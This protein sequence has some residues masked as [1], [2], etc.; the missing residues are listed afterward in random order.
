MQRIEQVPR[1]NQQSPDSPAERQRER[2]KHIR[3][4][5]ERSEAG[6]PITA[7][8]VLPILDYVDSS[9]SRGALWGSA[10]CGTRPEVPMP[11]VTQ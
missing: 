6:L 9:C 5:F 10:P 3:R 1:K 11:K 2:H 4:L 7:L 8:D